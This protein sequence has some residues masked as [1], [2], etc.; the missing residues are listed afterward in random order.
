MTK[1]F[2]DWKVLPHGE[3][4]TVTEGVWTVVGTLKMPLGDY[5]RRMT[6]V[7]LRDGR[8]VVYS[9]I[10]LDE[11]A[12]QRLEGYGKPAFL[13]VPGD[14]HRLDARPW[15]NRYP[16]LFVVAPPGA[17]EQVEKVVPVDAT[18]VDFGDAEVRFIAVPGTDGHEA[19][20]LIDRPSGATLVVNDLIWNLDDKPGLAGWLMRK[21][22]FT[23][24]PAH[25]PPL[26]ARKLVR[27][28]AAL[29]TQL[30]AWSR[31]DHL[32]RIIVSHGDIV[33]GHPRDVLSTIA[34]RLAA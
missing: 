33:S 11:S 19:A 2:E 30:E 4:T 34:R 12:M 3:L 14:I 29:R 27:D 23:G 21:A 1:P 10:A 9:A 16:D 26:V 22:G 13:V 24:R 15:K 25:I 18:E 20:L 31:V 8:L 17:R 5:P 28:R 32:D 7:R 6:V